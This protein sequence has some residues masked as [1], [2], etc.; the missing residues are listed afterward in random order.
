MAF[1][2]INGKDIDFFNSVMGEATY[3][4]KIIPKPLPWIEPSIN[5][6]YLEIVN[7]FIF[8]QYFS[9]ILTTGVLLNIF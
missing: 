6:P 8:G 7:S 2:I 4:Y 3:N 9:S 5:M 1:K